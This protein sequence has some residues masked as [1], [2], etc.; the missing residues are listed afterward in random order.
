MESVL[1]GLICD[2]C[3][4]YLDDIIVIG[5]T[6]H[7]RLDNLRKVFQGLRGTH[8]KMNP[9]KEVRYL[10]HIVSPQGVTTNPEKLEAVRY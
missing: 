6:F 3:F 4:V 1:M 8:L 5:R 7:E 2:A 10:G 9:E